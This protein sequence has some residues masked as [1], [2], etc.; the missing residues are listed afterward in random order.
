M[1]RRLHSLFAF[2][3]TLGLRRARRDGAL[4]LTVIAVLASSVILAIALPRLVLGAVDSGAREAVAEAGDGADIEITTAV[5]EPIPQIPMVRPEAV[6]ELAA[7]VPGRLP[8]DLARLYPELVVTVLSPGAAVVSAADESGPRITLQLGMLTP[9]ALDGITLA[10]GS[11]PSAPRVGGRTEIDVVLSAAG[12]AAASLSV[13]DTIEFRDANVDTV[14]AVVAGIVAPRDEDA[15]LWED[16]PTL[17]EPKQ[18]ETGSAVD[19]TVLTIPDGITAAESVFANPFTATMRLRPDPAAFSSDLIGPVSDMIDVLQAN[20]SQLAADSGA[21]LVVRSGFGSALDEYP[22]RARAAIAQMSVLIAGVLAVAAAVI[23]LLSRLLVLRRAQELA[24]ERARGASLASVVVR[25]LLESLAATAV[26]GAVGI[27]VAS[28]V[29]GLAS[30]PVP[31]AL[32]MLVGVCAAPVQSAALIVRADR[33]SRRI[34]ANRVDRR[35]AEGRGRARRLV[36]EASIVTL[37]AAALFAVRSRGLLQTRTDGIDPLLAAAPVLL[38]IAVTV[39]LLRIYP[40][41]V[42]FAMRLGHRTRGP[43]GILGA[44]QA[45]RALAVLPLASL[46]LAIA[47]AVSGGLLVETVRTGQVDA[48]WQRI[49]ADVRL[50]TSVTKAEIADVAAQPG[51]TA[52]SGVLA[53]HETRVAAGTV[54]TVVTLLAV[55]PEYG[56]VL[57][58]LPSGRIEGDDDLSALFVPTAEGDPL[59]VLVE[60]RLF[61]QL[62]DGPVALT[63]GGETRELIDVEVVGV[64]D[65]PADGY[66]RGPFV[67]IDRAALASRVSFSMDANTLLVIG[68]GADMAVAGLDGDISKRADWLSDRQHQALVAGVNAVMLVSTGAVAL[69]A[70]I[71]LVASVLAGARSRRRSLSLL[72]TLGL[73]ARL[74]WWLALSELAPLV[75]AAL[76]GGIAAGV[77]VILALGPSFGLE[78]L[79]GG[80]SPPMLAISPWVIAGVAAGAVLLSLIAM[81]VE[82]AAHRRDRLS[83]VL[84]VGESL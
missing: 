21:D 81:L 78:T 82:V 4:L 6:L 34:A 14:V 74:G 29:F 66:E 50:K 39:L 77:A 33:G 27:A 13:G 79:A 38:A 23:V 43:L 53:I 54:S 5:G 45:E 71:G 40:F 31:V 1:I 52:A 22:V 42:R 7:Q 64:F 37:A 59:P 44:M 47:L 56:E 36:L 19:L 35:E 51:V 70:L 16:T 30:D 28:T 84:R 83:D 69:L 15:A 18:S 17:W 11:L 25:S 67:Y 49:G 76:L 46:S 12:A 63:V 65:G 62:D 55:D 75:L 20:S 3:P 9:A 26:G 8:A 10:S 32:I 58:Q 73:S 72:R 68:P 57:A 41:V 60:E 24:L 2:A 80:V 48:S 61:R